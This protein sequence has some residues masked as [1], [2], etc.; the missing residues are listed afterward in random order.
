MNDS[1]VK[2]QGT[3]PQ[4]HREAAFLA[5][6]TGPRA[7][8]G[9]SREDQDELVNA[10]VGDTLELSEVVE[11]RPDWFHPDPANAEFEVLKNRQA[12]YWSDLRRDI[13]R[14]GIV[15]PLV[16]MSDGQVVQGH[17]RLKIAQELGIAKIPVRLVLAPLGPEEIQHRRRLDNLLRFELDEDTRLTLLAE[18]W[19]DFYTKAGSKG[20]PNNVAPQVEPKVPPTSE[21]TDHGDPFILAKEISEA[22]GKSVVQVK[23]DRRIVNRAASIAAE[24]GRPKPEVADIKAARTE[25]NGS[26]I[27]VKAGGTKRNTVDNSSLSI[28]PQ[29]ILELQSLHRQG[30][31]AFQKGMEQTL[32]A[33]KLHS[34][35]T[36]Q[37]FETI[38]TKAL[39]CNDLGLGNS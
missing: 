9:S 25:I 1:E 2:V 4:T 36:P 30:D 19:P 39:G 37:I 12:G 28:E 20:R 15:T 21:K 10:K 34:I 23:R 16:A 11:K 26:R 7:G 27:K 17:S 38:M 33:L 3:K 5:A 24:S 22:T 31:S 35:I 32:V 13:E 18:I 29:I 14:S 6:I 8:W